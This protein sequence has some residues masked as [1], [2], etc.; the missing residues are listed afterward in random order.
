MWSKLEK[1]DA[2][3]PTGNG[4]RAMKILAKIKKN[5]DDQFKG[6]WAYEFQ[7]SGLVIQAPHTRDMDQPWTQ[8]PIHC[9]WDDLW[10]LNSTLRKYARRI[11]RAVT[12]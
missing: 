8:K 5:F 10:Y 3:A 2:L 9:W 7:F 12:R 4:R 11:W 1:Q 6:R